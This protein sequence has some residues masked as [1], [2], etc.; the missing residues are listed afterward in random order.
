MK[1]KNHSLGVRLNMI[2]IRRSGSPISILQSH[3]RSSIR[4]QHAAKVANQILK[5]KQKNNMGFQ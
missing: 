1:Q 5:I 4:S 2:L 3:A